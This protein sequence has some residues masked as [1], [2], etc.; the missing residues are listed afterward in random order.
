VD[1]ACQR[2]EPTRGRRR[3]IECRMTAFGGHRPQFREN[4]SER[5]VEPACTGFAHD[6]YLTI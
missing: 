3:M 5:K 2:F 6:P 1:H 4:E